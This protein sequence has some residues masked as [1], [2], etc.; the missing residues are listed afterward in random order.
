MKAAA[1]TGTAALIWAE[2]T[3]KGL[4]RRPAYADVSSSNEPVTLLTNGVF[5]GTIVPGAA[6]AT[7]ANGGD[8]AVSLT[9]AVTPMATSVTLSVAGCICTITSVTSTGLGPGPTVQIPADGALPPQELAYT[10]ASGATLNFAAAS[11][12]PTMGELLDGS[13]Q[14]TC[15]PA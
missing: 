12:A 13:I 7:D 1:A 9:F 8:V 10:G 5:G 14:F 3:I 4:A 2:P 15:V 6:T 11:G